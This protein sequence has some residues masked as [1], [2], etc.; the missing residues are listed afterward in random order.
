MPN[1]PNSYSLITNFF[2]LSLA[3]LIA[4]ST[5]IL[6][7][8][9]KGFDLPQHYQ[10]AI[11]FY[12]SI[13]QGDIFPSWTSS[14]NYGYGDPGIRVYPPLAYYF[15]A[16]F[17]IITGNWFEAS[18][19]S[20][21]FLMIIG[22]F[23]VFLLA[24]EY[25]S[26]KES[27][28]AGIAYAFIPNH[29]F[30]LYGFF[31]YAEFAGT[32]F[33]PWCLLF[34]IRIIKRGNVYDI[35]GLSISTALLILTH[36]P[37]TVVCLF[38]FSVYLFMQLEKSTFFEKIKKIIIAQFIAVFLSAFY[39]VKLIETNWINH[40]EPKYS[41][42]IYDFRLNFLPYLFEK[43]FDVYIDKAF[44]IYDIFYFASLIFLVPLT[45]LYFSKQCLFSRLEA[46]YIKATL[47]TGLFALFMSTRLS[48]PIWEIIPII[49]KIQ[50]SSRW[51]TFFSVT[52]AIGFGYFVFLINQLTSFKKIL[53]KWAVLSF[54]LFI[55]TLDFTQITHPTS[56]VPFSRQEI[57]E[58]TST[59][60]DEE[61]F[62]CWWTIWSNKAAFSNT[63]L[64]I[65]NYTQILK[66]NNTLNIEFDSGEPTKVPLK[67]F[68][69]PHWRATVNNTPVSIE[70][71]EN[72]VILIPIPAKT[73]VVKLKFEEP[74]LVKTAIIISIVMWFLTI[75]YLL[76]SLRKFRS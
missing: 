40:S 1:Q 3:S 2:I 75:I 72:G 64:N 44:Y 61:S 24:K 55:L 5:I 7:G 32:A 74:I 65:R 66:S 6:F 31:L 73:S 45:Y 19:I 4:I 13:I 34:I 38:C 57:L 56:A 20:F 59:L 16:I 25:L 46:K 50:V 21:L 67:T 33:I 49:Q 42:G 53:L 18:W 8:I 30:Q 10:F 39:L 36:L 62:E 37:S 58:M 69:Y 51:L 26:D 70:K 35:L 54:S 28:L 68:Y 71:D 47:I 27:L 12:E 60:K 11:S 76:I 23:G 41:T 63:N 14:T 15:L 52:C 29:L 9:P 17:R 43:S 22:C 48:Q